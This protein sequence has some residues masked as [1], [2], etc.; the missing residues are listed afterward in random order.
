MLLNKSP[1]LAHVTCTGW[2][3]WLA[4]QVQ[5][6]LHTL[7]VLLNATPK[8]KSLI[9]N[10]FKLSHLTRYLVGHL[11]SIM[12]K[13]LLLFT[14]AIFVFTFLILTFVYRTADVPLIQVLWVNLQRQVDVV[15]H[16]P[17]LRQLRQLRKVSELFHIHFVIFSEW[18]QKRKQGKDKW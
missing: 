2:E 4:L 17:Q 18:I 11:K 5:L 10:V 3:T 12:W 15:P 1:A 16:P 8:V 14:R 7:K 6:A 13:D 9:V